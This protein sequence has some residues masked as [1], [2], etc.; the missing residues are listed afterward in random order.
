MPATTT[1]VGRGV[2]IVMPG[3]DLEVDVVAVAERQ[4]EHLA[5]DRGLVADAVDL[6]ALLETLGHALDQV[7]RPG[8]GTCPTSRGRPSTRRA[9]SPR[10]RRSRAPPSPRRARRR[11]ARPSRPSPSRS[12]RRPSPSRRT[13]PQRASCLL[14]TCSNLP[15]LLAAAPVLEDLAEHFAAHVP[16]P[17]LVIGH[18][19]LGRRENGDAETVGHARHGVDGRINAPAGL[20]DALDRADHRLAVIVLEL[21]RELGPA[22]AELG[23]ASSRGCSPRT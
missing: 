8:R 2:V 7:L 18:H 13:A 20:R 3:R 11:T 10:P 21:D 1:S 5:G 17:G 6:E 14:E 9:G 19:A 23:R 12:A 22:V 4:L 16:L 15:W